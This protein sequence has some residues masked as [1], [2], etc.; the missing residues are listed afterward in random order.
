[1]ASKKVQIEIDTKSTGNGAKQAADGLQKV[2]AE[3]EKATK[4]RVAAEE[5]AALK[6]EQA[7]KKAADAVIREEKRKT[8]AAE[9]EAAK[10]VKAEERAQ[11]QAAQ[12]S[13][14]AARGRSQVAGQVGMQVQDIAVQAQMGVQATTILAQQGSQLLG[15]FGPTGAIIG[16][17]LAIGA[18]AFGVFQKMGDDTTTAAEKGEFL[19][20]AINKIKDNAAKLQAEDIDYGSEAITRSIELAQILREGTEA[21]AAAEKKYSEQALV[22]VEKLRLAQV[23]I[24]EL[25]GEQVDKTAEASKQEQFQLSQ[26]E[27]KKQSEIDLQKSRLQSLENDKKIAQ[28]TIDKRQVA[29]DQARQL[30]Q[31]L[32]QQ[33]EAQKAQK[34]ELEKTAQGIQVGFNPNPVMSPKA[35][36]A[37]ETL[38]NTPFDTEIG[39][40]EKRIE[41]IAKATEGRN[42]QLQRS[43]QAAIDNFTDIDTAIPKLAQEIE[44]Q[45]QAIVQAADTE[46]ITTA[47]QNRV[48]EAEANAQ[49]V[50]AEIANFVPVNEIQAQALEAIKQR[51]GDLK[52]TA[53]ETAVVAQNLQTIRNSLVQGQQLNLSATDSIIKSLESYNIRLRELEKK[54][55]KLPAGKIN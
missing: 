46:A 17:I 31:T 3:S 5:R 4:R 51:T 50:N 45:T 55:Q 43:L 36:Q 33:V 44:V 38:A 54:A 10:R 26:I 39:A 15:V 40:L 6:A 53:D 24:R 20:D 12:A 28:E 37:K 14:K 34:A 1:M 16:G 8:A 52:I 19:A 23:A 49:A 2:G 48:K 27:A 47:V 41:E 35:I 7:A 11:T 42:S 25:K 13:A 21:V 30:L 32:Q 18:A 29:L 22:N 9:A